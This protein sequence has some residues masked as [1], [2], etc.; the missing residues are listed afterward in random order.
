LPQRPILS[1][2]SFPVQSTKPATYRLIG[3]PIPLRRWTC[4]RPC[5]F[6]Q[7]VFSG[8]A[9]TIPETP[10]VGFHVPPESCPVVP[11]YRF[12]RRRNPAAPLMSF[13]S[14]Q[15]SPAA[16]IHLARACHTRFGPPSGF[17]YPLDGFRPSTPG[18]P[19]FVLTA[20]LG[21]LTPFE[22]FPSRKVLDAITTPSEPACRS[23]RRFASATRRRQ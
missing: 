2:N 21:F 7:P 10:L 6:S 9:R 14:L 17:D 11:S 23:A 18:Q 20:L 15:H 8:I 1:W 19:Y 16:R 3:L 4:P 12:T 13:R 22:A 5:G